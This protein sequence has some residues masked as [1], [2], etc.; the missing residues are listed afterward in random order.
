MSRF[1]FSISV[2]LAV[3]VGVA[4]PILAGADPS[5]PG[6]QSSTLPSPAESGMP[7]KITRKEVR[8]IRREFTDLLDQERDALRSEQSRK[9]KEGDASRKSRRKEF[10]AREK[11]ARR[12]FF[13]ENAHGPERRTYVKDL[14]SRREAFLDG[15]KSEEKQERADLD[16]QWKELK[17]AQRN[18]LNAVED[19]LRRSERPPG[20]LLE[21][22]K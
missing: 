19:Y 9:R 1:P 16:G 20:R 5:D 12:K 14:T 2:L 3:T 18:R 17:D 15:L 4:T 8:R 13:E 21:R 10:D 6:A 22:V 11:A 7:E